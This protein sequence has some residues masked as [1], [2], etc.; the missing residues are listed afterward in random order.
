MNL[1]SVA[2]KLTE[3]S[4]VP[5]ALDAKHCT[6]AIYKSA[7]CEIC[8]RACPVNAIRFDSPIALD[9]KACVTCGA[10]VH[11]CP[12][13]VF[14]GDNGAADLF[15][16][17]SELLGAPVLELVCARHS[18]PASGPVENAAV[19]QTQGCLAAFGASVYLNLL[20]RIPQLVIRLDACKECALGKI[21]PEIL[22]T[23]NV[24]QNILNVRGEADRMVRI[25]IGG[26]DW[27]ARPVYS[28]KNPPV[29]RR[30]LF[31]MLASQGT[32]LA[33]R[34]FAPEPERPTAEKSAP[35]ERHYLLEAIR[36][37]PPKPDWQSAPTFG[38]GFVRL[39]ANEN[40]TACGVCARVCPTGALKLD[41]QPDEF[42]L[43]CAV[44]RCTDCG[45]CVDL[46]E[47]AALSRDGAPTFAEIIAPEP[48]VLRAGA[49][50]RCTRCG[51]RF[52]DAIEKNL[53]PVCEF[54]LRHP[55][56]STSPRA[57]ALRL[58]NEPPRA[59]V[60]P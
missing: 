58:K 20:T 35:L 42:R 51:A 21:Q 56:G 37:L 41:T 6:R 10:C 1:F 9:E 12:T 39:A 8:V 22:Q 18:S 60:P 49:L 47:P 13:G 29:S 48:L 53:C 46:C 50:K 7:P 19:I 3:P 16:C 27:N 5:I 11:L 59:E 54:R 52:A 24:V 14:S 28:V 34:A 15:K 32:S 57:G 36:Q 4:R 26:A 44:P 45:A 2:A 23:L 55:F 38:R 43:T 31:L 17:A 25:E 30:G 33:A 40:C